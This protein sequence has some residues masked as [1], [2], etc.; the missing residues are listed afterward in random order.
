MIIHHDELKALD[1]DEAL[2]VID[3]SSEGA[4]VV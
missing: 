2:E 1:T 3:I 4:E